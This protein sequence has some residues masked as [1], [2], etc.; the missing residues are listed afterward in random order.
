MKTWFISISLLLFLT[1]NSLYTW[2]LANYEI[3]FIDRETWKAS[4]Y[5][6]LLTA[7]FIGER[8]SPGFLL[9]EFLIISYGV[10][11]FSFVITILTNNFLILNPYYLMAI[12]DFGTL[13]AVIIIMTTLG[14][15]G[16][17]D[18]E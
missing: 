18:T 16:Y 12:V 8:L 17:F 5:T 4:N 3:A 2:W 6:F 15:E 7:I 10:L 14:K 1:S 9:R 13:L 11:F